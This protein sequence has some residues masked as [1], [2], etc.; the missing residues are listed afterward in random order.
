MS[1]RLAIQ[2]ESLPLNPRCYV[3]D[4]ILKIINQ[5]EGS[6]SSRCGVVAAKIAAALISASAKVFFIPISLKLI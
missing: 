1:V 2:N 4:S 5:R 3:E 6:D